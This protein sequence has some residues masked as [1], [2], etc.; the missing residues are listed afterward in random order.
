M[1]KS[2]RQLIGMEIEAAAT[3]HGGF[4]KALTCFAEST[5]PLKN[6]YVIY[7]GEKISFSDGVEAV[8]YQAVAGLFTEEVD[9]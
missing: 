7:S 2:A 6:K 1:H 8:P 4:K 5:S 3:W 9:D